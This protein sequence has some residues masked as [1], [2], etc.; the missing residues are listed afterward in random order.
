VCRGHGGAVAVMKCSNVKSTMCVEGMVERWL[1]QVEE[2]MVDSV[3]KV[4][5][6][7]H[8]AY[9]DTARNMWVLEWPGQTVICT[10]SIYW[11]AEV[12]EAMKKSSGVEVITDDFF[13]SHS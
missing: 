5:G 1:L 4:L 2:M 13:T 7:S 12:T 8:A 11:T 9:S 6:E 3:R 10:S